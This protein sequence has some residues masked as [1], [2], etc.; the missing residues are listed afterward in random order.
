[1]SDTTVRYIASTSYRFQ[2]RNMNFRFRWNFPSYKRATQYAL[3]QGFHLL[4]SSPS[5]SR[6][7]SPPTL[8]MHGF[9]S[10]L[11][12]ILSFVSFVVSSPLRS[13]A[14]SRLASRQ[15][16][17]PRALADTCAEL[18]DLDLSLALDLG[19]NLGSLSSDVCLCLS[20]FPLH[21]DLDAEVET[22]VR[23]SV[24]YNVALFALRT[25]MVSSKG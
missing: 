24:R 14:H 20:A 17:Y 25:L 22:L 6:S 4:R 1:M 16:H 19:L 3:H 8:T 18:D 12:S 11:V 10:L 5:L 2:K 21:L 13:S 9:T 7:F 23:S 15:F